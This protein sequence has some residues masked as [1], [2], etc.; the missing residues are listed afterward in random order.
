VHDARVFEHR[1]ALY[2]ELLRSLHAEVLAC[3]IRQRA[4]EGEALEGDD[5]EDA[6]NWTARLG[7]T[8]SEE[9]RQAVVGFTH[10]ARR[11]HASLETLQD[12]LGSSG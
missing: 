8:A 10:S 12:A 4:A 11:F 9:V 1:A 7:S 6:L 2:A 3:W 5:I